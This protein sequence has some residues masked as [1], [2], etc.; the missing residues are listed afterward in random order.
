[1]RLHQHLVTYYLY[2]WVLQ[3]IACYTSRI[4]LESS[5]EQEH[6]HA[7]QELHPYLPIPHAAIA[8]GVAAVRQALIP[9]VMKGRVESITAN[10]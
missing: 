2:R 10:S 6:A 3:E 8:S 7:W 9:F 5:D 4:L 1:M